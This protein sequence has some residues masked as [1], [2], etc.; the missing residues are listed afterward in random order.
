MKVFSIKQDLFKLQTYEKLLIELIVY[1][2][3]DN[4]CSKQNKN[5]KIVYQIR[6]VFFLKK[7]DEFCMKCPG[8]T[9]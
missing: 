4:F 8:L 5:S 9:F 6:E 7:K 2:L 3:L 1:A